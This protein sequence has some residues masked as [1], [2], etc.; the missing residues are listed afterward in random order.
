MNVS[1]S[2]S[3]EPAS[4]QFFE[5][6]EDQFEWLQRVAEVIERALFVKRRQ[7]SSL[8]VAYTLP[9]DVWFRIFQLACHRFPQCHTTDYAG[10][11]FPLAFSRSVLHSYPH[12]TTELSLRKMLQYSMGHEHV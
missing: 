1:R 9:D 2:K 3:E 12:S 8:S 5:D 7:I 4:S 11:K 10:A 6:R